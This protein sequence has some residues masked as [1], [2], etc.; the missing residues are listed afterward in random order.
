MVVIGGR[1]ERRH[2]DCRCRQRP[3]GQFV[4]EASFLNC[5]IM[6][7]VGDKDER[8]KAWSGNVE[9]DAGIF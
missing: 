6:R 4:P 7:F 1:T 3:P 2:G 8:G 9:R 5:S